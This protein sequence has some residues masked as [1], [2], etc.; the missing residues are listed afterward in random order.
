[1]A[2]RMF[3]AVQDIPWG[4]VLAYTRGQT[5]PESIVNEHG[6]QDYVSGAGTKAAAEVQAD[7][8]GRDVSD[9][10]TGSAKSS[11]AP[12]DAEKKG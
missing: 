7:V 12:A 2:E 4:G 9:F 6:W 1:M 10:Q 8:S 11:V 5:I 3:I